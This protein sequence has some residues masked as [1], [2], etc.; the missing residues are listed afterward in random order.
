MGRLK[1]LRRG[2]DVRALSLEILNSGPPIPEE[3]LPH[4]FERFFRGNGTRSEGAHCGIGL[5]LV[6]GIS[7]ALG[8]AVTAHNT[9]DGGVSF[10]VRRPGA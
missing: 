8:L 6:R 4:L 7:D 9:A 5:A 2:R 3:I 10:A 1:I